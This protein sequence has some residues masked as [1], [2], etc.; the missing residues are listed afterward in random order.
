MYTPEDA[1]R[2]DLDLQ[3]HE[4]LA[5]ALEGDGLLLDAVAALCTADRMAFENAIVRQEVM[6]EGRNVIT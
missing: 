6:R 1:L 3:A 5:E 2:V 4:V